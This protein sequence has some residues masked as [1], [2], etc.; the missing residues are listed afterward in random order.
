MIEILFSNQPSMG[1]MMKNMKYIMAVAW[2]IVVNGGSTG[3]VAAHVIVIKVATKVQNISCIKGR[4][5]IDRIYEVCVNG[6]VSRMATDITRATV[7]PSLFGIDR[8]I[9]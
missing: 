4:N 9:P 7:P 2:P 1:F 3:L 8:R 5:V 6:I